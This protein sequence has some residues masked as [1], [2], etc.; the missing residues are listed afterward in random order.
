MCLPL[1]GRELDAE[2]KEQMQRKQNR[3]DCTS[4]AKRERQDYTRSAQGSD[5]LSL[6]VNLRQRKEQTVFSLE[7]F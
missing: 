7:T 3:Q 2:N 6:F 1:S 4:K 5:A